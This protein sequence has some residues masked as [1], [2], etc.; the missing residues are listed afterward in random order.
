M[1]RASLAAQ[2]IP[3]ECAPLHRDTLMLGP[4]IN[5]PHLENPSIM[6]NSRAILTTWLAPSPTKRRCSRNF[7]PPSSHSPPQMQHSWDKSKLSLPTINT[8][9]VWH[10][11]RQP[12]ILE[13]E[14]GRAAERRQIRGASLLASTA[15]RTYFALAR[16]TIAV[17]ASRQD[18]GTNER[19]PTPNQWAGA[20]IS[21]DGTPEGVGSLT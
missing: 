10:V 3:W 5:L 2:M 9:V 16:T 18:G 11:M 19:L 4:P 14:K 12:P 1:G 21:P 15:T 20:R 6:R 13:R 8:S 7:P 17:C